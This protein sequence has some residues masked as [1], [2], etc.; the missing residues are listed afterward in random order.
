MNDA[1]AGHPCTVLVN[2]LHAK[3]GGGVTYL[4]A[5]LPQ[6]AT[7]GRLELVLLGHRD[8]LHLLEPLDGRIRVHPVELPGGMVREMLWEQLRLP[9][10][11]RGL[12]ADVVFSPANFGPLAVPNQVIVLRND[13]TV[14]RD[15]PRLAKKL[16]WWALAALTWASLARVRRAVAVSAYAA[17]RLS[18]GFGAKVRVVHHGVAP[19]FSPDP[20]V[21][22]EGF[23]LTVSDVYVQKNLLTLVRALAGLPGIELRVAGRIVDPWYHA[24]VMALAAELGV[25]DRLTFLGRLDEAALVDL[26]RRCAA[27]V[28]P[29]TAETFGNPLVE[30]MA[31]GAPVACSNAAAMPEIVGDAALLFDPLDA[32]AMREALARLLGDADL[33]GELSGRALRRGGAFSWAATARATADLLVEAARGC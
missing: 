3:S 18:F 5:M 4:R 11:A 9:A 7:D 12:G 25:A 14:G 8:L 26:Y 29:S 28:F 22:R 2:A 31:C 6:L 27:F 13:V 10:V 23:L 33:R 21:R 30:A 32:A 15:E 24:Q 19:A 17:E 20:A 16:Y 1:L